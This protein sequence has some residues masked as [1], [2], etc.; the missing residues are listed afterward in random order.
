MILMFGATARIDASISSD[1]PD[2]RY[3]SSAGSSAAG[4]A[5][6]EFRVE[7]R[8]IVSGLTSCAHPAVG[9]TT[10]DVASHQARRCRRMGE[11]VTWALQMQCEQT[12]SGRST[13]PLQSRTL[14]QN[15]PV[16]DCA[17]ALPRLREGSTLGYLIRRQTG[18]RL[19]P[20]A[21]VE[22]GREGGDFPYGRLAPA[23]LPQCPDVLFAHE[24][25]RLGELAGVTK[26]RASLNVQ[27]VFGPRGGELVT[28]VLVSGEA[29]DRRRVKTQSGSA[30]HLAVDHRGQ[31]LALQPAER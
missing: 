24:A 5:A 14:A 21:E 20:A 13:I 7:P 18:H 29:T 22:E 17:S 16:P 30:P 2:E 25:R 28:Q 8:G 12:D 19:H 11:R 3:T 6:T 26:Q 31:H 23:A 1:I 27:V 10:A 15:R 9:M 4:I